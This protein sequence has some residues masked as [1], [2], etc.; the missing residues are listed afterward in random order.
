M[1][2]NKQEKV[3]LKMDGIN[4][5]A[6]YGRGKEASEAKEAGRD[7]MYWWPGALNAVSL[8]LDGE[9]YIV[10]ERKDWEELKKEKHVNSK[11]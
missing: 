11:L 6:I 5:D 8:E 9:G 7:V 10:F 4:L 1:H 2:N 3:P